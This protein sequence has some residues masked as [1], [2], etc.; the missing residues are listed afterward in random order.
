MNLRHKLERKLGFLAIPNLMIVIV[1]TMFT[2]F[3]IDFLTPQIRI[4]GWLTLS[5]DHVVLQGQFWRI[6]SFL[7]VPLNSSPLFIIFTL[8]FYYL[9]GSTLER[10]WG[11][12]LFNVYYLIGIV[13]MILCAMLTG[14]A[15]N[16]Y[17]NLS[18][19]FAFAF[20]NPN[21]QVLLFFVLPLKIKYL[22]YANAAIFGY[23]LITEDSST[24]LQIIFSVVNLF[25]FFGK[26]FYHMARTKWNHRHHRK[27]W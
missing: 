18:L 19:F 12:F 15:T 23:L 5:W 9:I 8:Y 11:T 7:F 1:A 16:T 14:Y 4:I 20:L 3:L 2:V 6:I 13:G 27:N 22:A 26:D 25:L 24:R 17:L 10:H 21:F